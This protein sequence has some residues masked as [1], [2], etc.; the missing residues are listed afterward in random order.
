MQVHDYSRDVTVATRKQSK[1]GD[2]AE[3]FCKLC[4][5]ARSN[6]LSKPAQQSSSKLQPKTSPRGNP[7]ALK[8]CSDCFTEIR[9]GNPH[10]CCKE[11]KLNNLARMAGND[12]DNFVSRSL[13][14]RTIFK[15]NMAL[16]NV[17]GKPTRATIIKGTA[18][19]SV[20]GPISVGQILK[21]K[22]KLNLSTRKVGLLFIF[23]RFS[24]F[25]FILQTNKLAQA[26][27]ES[28]AVSIQPGLSDVLT[29]S[30]HELDNFFDV[31]QMSF[32]KTSGN[33]TSYTQQHL[34][35]CRSV[36][37]LV[38]YVKGRRNMHD[39]RLIVGMNSGQG[40]LK[41]ILNIEDK[42]EDSVRS[43]Y[44]DSGVKRCFVLA[45]V[46][47]VQENYNNVSKIWSKLELQ[48]LDAVVTGS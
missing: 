40:S 3:H 19:S 8:V 34:V 13:R 43:W 24:K 37:G 10:S 32:T 46:G 20:R 2:S 39:I 26:L 15:S 16:K 4:A 48:L 22:N 38:E 41:I 45:L 18:G 7:K 29:S 27:R 42:G 6:V 14:A 23:V 9:Q 25:L 35:Y 44:K 36:H 33:S 31:E 12:V 30:A 28:K 47:D 5:V 1:I 11:I 21:I 17:R